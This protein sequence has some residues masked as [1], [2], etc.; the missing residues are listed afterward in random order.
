MLDPV[1]IGSF[2]GV[3]DIQRGLDTRSCTLPLFIACVL[4]SAEKVEDC[5]ACGGSSFFWEMLRG[6]TRHK[7]RV[8]SGGTVSYLSRLVLLAPRTLC[9]KISLARLT[10]PVEI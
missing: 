9:E 1:D 7:S 3:E 10:A 5:V 8:A 2:I 6:V 4:G